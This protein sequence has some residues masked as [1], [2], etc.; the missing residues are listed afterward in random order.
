MQLCP[1]GKDETKF[2]LYHFFLHL[3]AHIQTQLGE[4]ESSPVTVLVARADKLC[5]RGSWAAA[6]VEAIEEE[7]LTVTPR[8]QDGKEKRGHFRGR[9][10]PIP[11]REPMAVATT[12]TSPGPG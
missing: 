7:V 1:I 12:M 4:D 5:N 8:D 9:N 11:S 6:N 2:F 3:S 10:P